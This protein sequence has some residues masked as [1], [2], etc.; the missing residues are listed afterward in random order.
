[1]NRDFRQL[2]HISF[3]V[4]A[5]LGEEYMNGLRASRAA[6]ERNVTDNLYIRHIQ[7]LFLGG[8]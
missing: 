7:P 4:A 2:I 6:I 8:N 1:M 5:E 3:R